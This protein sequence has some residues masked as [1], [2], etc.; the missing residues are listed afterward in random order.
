MTQAEKL[1][2]DVEKA[3]SNLVDKKPAFTELNVAWIV[4]ND[5]ATLQTDTQ[6]FGTGFVA[7]VPVRSTSVLSIRV[8]A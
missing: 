3:L 5:L 4:Q 6:K 2:S 7:K 1:A 8:G